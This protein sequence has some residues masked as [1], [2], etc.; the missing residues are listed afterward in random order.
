M[1]H[2]DYLTRVEEFI[3]PFLKKNGYELI[4][5][6]FTEEDHNWYLRLY[7]DLSDVEAEKRAA[8]QPVQSEPDE[9]DGEERHEPGIGINDCAKVSRYLSTW[10]DK[11]DFIS[12][13]YTLEVCSKGFLNEG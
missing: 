8:S 11:T 3:V 7:I 10:L 13:T 5:S 4:T 9:E 12:E 6:E 2:K 1:E